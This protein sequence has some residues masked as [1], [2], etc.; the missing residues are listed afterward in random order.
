MAVREFSYKG[1]QVSVDQD[2]DQ[3]AEVKI[4]GRTFVFSQQGH[5]LPMWMCDEAYFGA[6]ALDEVVRHL[7][8]YWYIVT[9]EENTA[10][11]IMGDHGKHEERRKAR[12]KPKRKP[13]RRSGQGH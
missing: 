7:V 2:D 4:D 6:P 1:K 10:P 11:P 9:D 5:N 12:A 3:R 8:D 13:A